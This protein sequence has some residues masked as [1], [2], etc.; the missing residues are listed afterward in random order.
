MTL[1]TMAL[2]DPGCRGQAGDSSA[3]PLVQHTS[4]KQKR[5]CIALHVGD[6]DSHTAYALNAELSSAVPISESSL[7]TLGRNG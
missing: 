5:A 7:Q 6:D 3:R 4:M 1:I 2:Q